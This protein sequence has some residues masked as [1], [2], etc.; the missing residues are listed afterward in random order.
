MCGRPGCPVRTSFLLMRLRCSH[1][2]K[3]GCNVELL[4]CLPSPCKT[5][6]AWHARH[7]S[8]RF[9]LFLQRLQKKKARQLT[10]FEFSVSIIWMPHASHEISST[11]VTVFTRDA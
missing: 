9:P 8:N 11:T 2:R 4:A 6:D 5:S 1:R 10:A 7:S 3:C